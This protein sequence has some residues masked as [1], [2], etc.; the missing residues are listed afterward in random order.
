[1]ISAYFLRVEA[2]IVQGMPE[3]TLSSYGND[4]TERLFRLERDTSA[5]SHVVRKRLSKMTIFGTSVDWLLQ[6]KLAV[7]RL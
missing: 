1:M 7:P 3:R 2:F 6:N 5:V 4:L